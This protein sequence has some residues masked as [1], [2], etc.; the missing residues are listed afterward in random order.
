MEIPK[1][2]KNDE[3]L[4]QSKLKRILE[5]PRLFIEES[6]ESE[7]DEPK[8]HLD[9]GDAVDLLLTGAEREFHETFAV[10]K[11]PRPGGN[12]GDF[13]WAKFKYRDFDTAD[14]LAYDEVGIKRP[15]T[16]EAYLEKFE[17]EGRAYYDELV[18]NASKRLLTPSKYETI[19][20]IIE[21]IKNNPE[22]YKH[23][24][25]NNE[26]YEVYFQVPLYFRFNGIECKGLCDAIKVHKETRKATVIDVKTT[27]YSVSNFP[28]SFFQ[29][30]YDFQGAWYYSGLEYDI[31]TQRLLN[32]DSVESTVIFVVGSSKFPDQSLAYHMG[33]ELIHAAHQGYVHNNKL[34]EG[35]GKALKRFEFHS[36]LDKW[37]YKMEE[38]QNEFNLKIN[39]NG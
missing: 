9:I 15:A 26:E 11:V 10:S 27:R 21:S 36:N 5:H 12:M 23:I 16:V 39:V 6:F 19:T 32:I 37:D 13:C 20:R 18:G 35:I 33:P 30:R 4:N 1:T 29:L 24:D 14:K 17:V 2:Y 28:I 3:S 7:F 31:E 25:P 8:D 22:V 34:K 38:Y